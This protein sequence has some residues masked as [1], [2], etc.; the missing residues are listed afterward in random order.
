M[1]LIKKTLSQNLD[2]TVK[3]NSKAVIFDRK[4]KGILIA[5]TNTINSMISGVKSQSRNQTCFKLSVS[6]NANH[7]LVNAFLFV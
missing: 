1:K 4:V 7:E 5:S 6:N 3:S 2:L